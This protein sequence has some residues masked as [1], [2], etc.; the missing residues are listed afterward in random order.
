MDP[1]FS[2]PA[3]AGGFVQFL[4]E[5]QFQGCFRT[6]SYD[7]TLTLEACQPGLPGSARRA[8]TNYYVSVDEWKSLT[9][10]ISF[11]LG[12]LWVFPWRVERLWRRCCHAE[13]GA[14]W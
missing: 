10:A 9:A 14:V 2:T 11:V 5:M 12:S 6:R 4:R 3:I 8:A 13:A 7:N 1:Q